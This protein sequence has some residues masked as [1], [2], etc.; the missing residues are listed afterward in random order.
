MTDKIHTTAI[1]D[2]A[3]AVEDQMA[4]DDNM[5]EDIA[6]AAIEAYEFSLWRPVR[7]LEPRTTAIFYRPKSGM[8]I[9]TSGHRYPAGDF[10]ISFDDYTISSGRFTRFRPI[11]PPQEPSDAE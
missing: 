5:P 6:K 8:R 11:A 9:G 1:G 7:E 4:S 2:A 10:L 3:K